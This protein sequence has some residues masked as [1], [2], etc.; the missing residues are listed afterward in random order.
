VSTDSS[1]HQ[2]A[3]TTRLPHPL[4]RPLLVLI[5]AVLTVIAILVVQY[6][7]SRRFGLNDWDVA[8][9]HLTDL[10]FSPDNKIIAT[11]SLGSVSLWNASTKELIAGLGQSSVATQIVFAPD[12]DTFAWSDEDYALFCDPVFGRLIST[13]VKAHAWIY[14]MAISPARSILSS[15]DILA[16]G[17]RTS[18]D[19]TSAVEL[20]NTV[21]G[22]I[23]HVTV[24]EFSNDAQ[25][26]SLAFSNDGKFLAAGLSNGTVYVW[27][28]TSSDNHD[29]FKASQVFSLA[30]HLSPIEEI[31]IAPDDISL[32][33]GSRN[34]DVELVN[35][36]DTYHSR[37]P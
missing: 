29:D 30:T 32:A 35:M 23:S 20:W 5:V 18:A 26:F 36:Q 28:I 2:T 16:T 13:P 11:Y 6:V 17:G 9:S 24:A 34:G 22:D 10:R 37:K 21:L 19:G 3:R 15:T 33:L 12:G 31:A 27:E 14:A 8:T 4:P 25:V 1:I 7:A